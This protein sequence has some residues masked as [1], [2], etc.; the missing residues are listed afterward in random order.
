M[1]LKIAF[2]TDKRIQAF[3]NTAVLLRADA[4]PDYGHKRD[5]YS[6]ICEGIPRIMHI[7][8]D[9][10]GQ[11]KGIFSAKLE[12]LADKQIELEN[13]IEEELLAKVHYDISTLE[14]AKVGIAAASRRRLDSQ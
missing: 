9:S 6:F 2:D 8:T 13:G 3:V 5:I 12:L 7:F 14:A 11:I 1:I 4:M 10:S